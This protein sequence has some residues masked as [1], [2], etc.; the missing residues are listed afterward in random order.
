MKIMTILLIVASKN[1]QWK[2]L[3]AIFAN[4]LRCLFLYLAEDT[5]AKNPTFSVLYNEWIFT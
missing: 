4:L 1:Q 3:T 5:L 2:G